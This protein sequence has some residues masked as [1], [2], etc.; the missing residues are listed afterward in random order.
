[1]TEMMI[2]K[3]LFWTWRYRHTLPEEITGHTR[4]LQVYLYRWVV[5]GNIGVY[6]CGRWFETELVSAL[7]RW[8]PLRGV[9]I[10]E[11]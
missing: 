5:R 10:G 3:R 9:R 4:T 11:F 1:M 8:L 7:L 2:R 6:T